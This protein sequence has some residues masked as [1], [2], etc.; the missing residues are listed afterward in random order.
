[1]RLTPSFIKYKIYRQYQT[2]KSGKMIPMQ[3]FPLE[4][5]RCEHRKD[6]QSDYFLN[7]FELHQ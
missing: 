7:H 5:N 1:M 3:R 4:K 6:N 2:Y